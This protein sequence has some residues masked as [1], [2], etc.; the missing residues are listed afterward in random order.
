MLERAGVGQVNV[1][2]WSSGT[3]IALELTTRYPDR[4]RGIRRWRRIL[5]VVAPV[6]ALAWIT[7]AAVRGAWES[8]DPT[9]GVRTLIG[10]VDADSHAPGTRRRRHGARARIERVEG[11]ESAREVSRSP[12]REGA[13]GDGRRVA[14]RR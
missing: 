9:A 8:Y 6:L 4:V 7:V 11:A 10:F 3:P 14:G 5:Y 1:V 13:Q 12:R 2:S